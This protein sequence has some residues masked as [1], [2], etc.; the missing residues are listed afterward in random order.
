[1]NPVL[2]P[3]VQAPFFSVIVPTYNRADLLPRS[4]RSILAQSFQAFEVIVIDDGSTDDTRNAIGQF[5]DNR[6]RY[7]YQNN[8]GRCAARNAGASK[9]R[10]PIL[11]FLDSD[12]EVE[13][14]WLENL[15]SGFNDSETGVVCC[16]VRIIFQ[17]AQQQ[18][19]LRMPKDLGPVYMHYEGLFITGTFALRK[20]IFEEVGGYSTELHYAETTDLAL[21]IVSYCHANACKIHSISKPL[22]LYHRQLLRRAKTI[23]TYQQRLEGARYFIRKHGKRYRDASPRGYANYCAIAGVNA[24]RLKMYSEAREYFLEAIRKN[25]LHWRHYFRYILAMSPRVSSLF[26]LRFEGEPGER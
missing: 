13:Q 25:P 11:V 12:D 21:R 26:W 24:S 1:M 20:T 16:G 9:A 5:S 19:K 3:D 23:E 10:A 4:L 15:A 8:S 2:E 6:V 14:E 18:E 22:V 17:D 7:F